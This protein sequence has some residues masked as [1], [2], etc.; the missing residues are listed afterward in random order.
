MEL[1]TAYSYS[2]KDHGLPRTSI[3]CVAYY[4][5]VDTREVNGSG[6]TNGY[7]Y[8]GANLDVVYIVNDVATVSVGG[9][10][11]AGCDG[12]AG[13]KSHGRGPAP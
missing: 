2:L 10:F 12:R 8:G 1:S 13:R 9:R 3:D 11:K 4:G 5:V 7:S 6:P